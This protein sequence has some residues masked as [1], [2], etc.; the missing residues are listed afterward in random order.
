MEDPEGHL[1]LFRARKTLAK[2]LMDRGFDNNQELISMF[3]TDFK[4]LKGRM[5]LENTFLELINSAGDR[6]VIVAFVVVDKFKKDDILKWFEYA[7]KQAK[8]R[9]LNT[10]LLIVLAG[11]A[12][13]TLEK[14]KVE[15]NHFHKQIKV[16]QDKKVYVY[17]ELWDAE[18]LQYNVTESDLVPK[19]RLMLPADVDSYLAEA[20][21]VKTQLPKIKHNDPVARY[22]GA[23]P[24]EVMK[25]E[26]ISES[27]GVPFYYR[28]V[29]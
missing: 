22:F 12:N 10:H 16:D 1:F 17:G 8:E 3:E 26:R 6:Q 27:S 25:I 2:M 9:K 4:D 29:I 24:G 13:S 15:Q 28:M 21:L 14:V 20:K 19:H 7:V 11:K 23:R 5:K 18:S